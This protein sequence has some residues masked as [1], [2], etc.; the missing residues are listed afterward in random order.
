MKLQE[1]GN[2]GEFVGGVA[3]IISLIY[4]AMQIRQ[5]T[6]SVRAST[7]QA[8][9]DSLSL[10]TA[11]IASD[12]ELTRIYA[13]GLSDDLLEQIDRQRFNL[14]LVSAIRRFE[15]AFLQARSEILDS[16]Q[17]SGFSAGGVSILVSPGGVAWWRE[18]GRALFTTEFQDFVDAEIERSGPSAFDSGQLTTGGA[19]QQSNEA[20]ME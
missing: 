18:M 19:A 20:G 17:W 1:L 7:F 8:V 14:L 5:N 2:I 3:V 11:E 13:A 6:R 4:V 10:F 16:Q 12:A 15:S 9:A